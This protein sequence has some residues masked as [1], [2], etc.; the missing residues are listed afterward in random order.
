[1][2]LFGTDRYR[3]RLVMLRAL[4]CNPWISLRVDTAVSAFYKK[5]T[6]QFSMLK[7]SA[8]SIVYFVDRLAAVITIASFFTVPYLFSQGHL[9]LVYQV[10]LCLLNGILV[11]YIYFIFK[12]KRYRY[13]IIPEFFHFVNHNARDWLYLLHKRAQRN[14]LRDDDFGTDFTKNTTEI[15]DQIANA[16]SHLTGA[17]CAVC[18]KQLGP[19]REVRV[20]FRDSLSAQ[21][22][23]VTPPPAAH[24]IEKDTPCWSVYAKPKPQRWYG[25]N[26]VPRDWYKQRFKS[27][28]FEHFEQEPRVAPFFGYHRPISWPLEFRSCLVVPIRY[29]SCS[30]PPATSDD[31]EWNYWGFLCIDSRHRNVFDFDRM[32]PL[33]AGFADV[34]FIYFSR[35]FD[36]LENRARNLST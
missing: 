30:T 4:S 17:R 13:A 5:H 23:K 29:A 7:R 35:T 20:V 26:N 22:R 8:D 10:Y 28:S 36:I 11:V 31:G 34:L 21:K 12:N 9:M 15:L 14:E 33:A 6:V 19:N 24:D 25:S 3:C 2:S 27:A 18:I 32:W 1:M 16:F